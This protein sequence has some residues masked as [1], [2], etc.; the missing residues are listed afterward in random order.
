MF[1]ICDH[2]LV[3]MLNESYLSNECHEFILM[4]KYDFQIKNAHYNCIYLC[5]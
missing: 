3:L 1:R 4:I 2:C 5:C